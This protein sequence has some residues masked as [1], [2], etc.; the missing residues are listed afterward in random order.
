VIK[1][2][3]DISKSSSPISLCVSFC[4]VLSFSFLCYTEKPRYCHEFI[5]QLCFCSQCRCS[6]SVTC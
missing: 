6:A 1:V 4:M 5:T 2:G 3:K